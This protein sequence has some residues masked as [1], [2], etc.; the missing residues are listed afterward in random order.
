MKRDAWSAS[1]ASRPEAAVS[2]PLL[3]LGHSERG[4]G[5]VTLLA[6]VARRAR[7]RDLLWCLAVLFGL[8][9]FTLGLS[10]PGAG[11]PNE[12][13]ATV[14][15]VRALA[16]LL[17]A[18]GLGSVGVG[19]RYEGAGSYYRRGGLETLL[20]LWLVWLL[21]L[22]LEAFAFAA[23]YPDVPAWW[24]LAGP[25]LDA[26]AYFG[27]GLLLGRLTGRSQ[28]LAPLLPPLVLAATVGLSAFFEQPLL[29][30]LAAAPQFS[31]A[32]A[33]V[34]GGL[35]LAVVSVCVRTYLG[36]PDEA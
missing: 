24:L 27:V 23:S 31:W 1:N 25:L 12:A 21:V 8:L 36:G 20:A 18:V 10:W 9:V 32:Y 5:F 15:Q 35:T 26:G 11:V 7:E 29:N 14:A 34:S 16:L 3:N 17:I 4:G 33:A 22:P 2:N 28:L 13:W 30:P 6:D 19:T